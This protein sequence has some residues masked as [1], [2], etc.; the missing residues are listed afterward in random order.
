MEV[1]VLSIGSELLR[2]DI[3]DTNATFLTRSLSQLGMRTTEVRQVGDRIEDLTRAISDVLQRASLLVCTGGLG[4]TQDD[5]TREAIAA[6]L[7][8]ELYTDETLVEEL[9]TRFGALRRNMPES[10]LRQAMLI[11]SAQAVAN[12][13]GTAPG[14]YV[15]HSGRIVVAMP[16]PPHEMQPMWRD[17]ILPRVEALVAG[18]TAMRS[19]VT[20][21]IGESALERRIEELLTRHTDVTIA[22]YAKP[23]GVEVHVTARGV[24]SAEAERLL[25]DTES[26]IRERLGI[27]VFGTDGDTLA[28]VAGRLLAAQ[29]MT[30]GVME[31]CTGGMLAS[32]I[33]DV[34]GSSDCF[35]GGIVAYTREIKEAMGVASHLL[36]EH[37]LISSETALSMARTAR[38]RLGADVGIG[39]TGVAGSEPLEGH[40]PGTCFV[41]VSLPDREEVREIHRPGPRETIKRYFSL[42]ALDLLRREMG[43]SSL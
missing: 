13:N 29:H 27:H 24:T 28:A 39:T 11:P 23:G 19:L 33:T 17:Q 3:Q 32:L 42:C 21:G 25:A 43:N 18:A 30:V 7:G 34:P 41:A 22:T 16:G 20:F 14:W 9:K 37:G 8:E 40:A 5:L 35:R 15:E 26:Q 4:P 31:S 12:P 36:A 38:S 6:S 10:N 2:G 1:A